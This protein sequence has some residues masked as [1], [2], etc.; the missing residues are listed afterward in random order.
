MAVAATPV[1][2]G[3]SVQGRPI[4]AVRLGDPDA[5]HRA[6]VVAGTHGDE[7]GTRRITR[8]LRAAS[9]TGVD[10]WVVDA[11]NPDGLRR[12]TRANAHGVDLNRNFPAGWRGS[13]R[14]SRY[15]GGPR[16]SSEPETRA[17]R[18][19]VLRVRPE[20]SLWLHQPYRWVYLPEGAPRTARYLAQLLGMPTHPDDHLPGTAMRWAA[21][22]V[23]G[24]ASI[25]VEYGERAPDAATVARSVRAILRIA[26]HGS[27]DATHR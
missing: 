12:H 14:G 11:L 10:L 4:T 22:A 16:A 8:A 6:L 20:I 3:H 9:V 2:L 15:Y 23:P 26:R 21:R 7:P 19:L 18:K 24:S 5:P 17:I 27:R 13:A 25:T 1:V